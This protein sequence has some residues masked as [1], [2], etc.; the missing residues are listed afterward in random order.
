MIGREQ[1][2][3]SWQRST[4]SRGAPMA[5][6]EPPKKRVGRVMSEV[7]VGAL[8]LGVV[9]VLGGVVALI[10]AGVLQVSRWVALGN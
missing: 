5:Q 8:V 1:S 4:Y 6:S 3:L 7:Y 2:V 9:A 10:I